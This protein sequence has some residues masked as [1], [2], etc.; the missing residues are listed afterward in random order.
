MIVEQIGPA[1]CR[2]YLL[3]CE[4]TRHGLLVD[5]LLEDVERVMEHLAER[6]V[7]LDLVLDTH[8]HADHLSGGAEFARATGTPYAIHADSAT[9][10]A[11]ERLRDDQEIE[12]GRET[13]RVLHT[14]GHTPCSVSI[15]SDQDLFTGDFLFLAQD[16]AGRLD[17][18]GGDPGVHWDSLRRLSALG[19][20]LR[21]RPG[22]DYS[23]L[24]DSTL[25]L[26][27][28]RNPR[29][30][31][32]ER[33][34]Y[35]AWQRAVAMD[36]PDWMLEMIAANLGRARE[37]RAHHAT[38][39]VSGDPLAA[40][41]SGGAC[42]AGPLAAMPLIRPETS[43]AR[44]SGSGPVPF[45]IDVREPWEYAMRHAPGA[46]LIPLGELPQRLDE[47]PQDPELEIHV[48]CRSGGRSAR[49]TAFLI[50]RGWR[51][52]FNIATGTDGWV[53]SG[54]PVER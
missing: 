49:A 52:V 32:I 42:S 33:D 50:D 41:A 53:E 2:S 11:G 36:T 37:H 44:R 5:P 43:H 12:V 22:H 30:Q 47:V 23:G 26:E 24:T 27:R 17:L 16:G 15:L 19:D 48:I 6:G 29:F 18:P 39:P 20:Q 4:S 25:G 14:P 46:H 35:V 9:T 28:R 7:E 31:N 13:V 10:L 21:V 38:A 34:E 40:C 1:A 8:T 45:L 54:L 51:R 3:V